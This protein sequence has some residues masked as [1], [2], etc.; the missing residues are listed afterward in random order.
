MLQPLISTSKEVKERLT[1]FVYNVC[2]KQLS[3]FEEHRFTFYTRDKHYLRES[4]AGEKRE[5]LIVPLVQPQVRAARSAINGI[6][7]SR[8]PIF[9][10]VAGKEFMEEAAVLTALMARDATFYNW[11]E[12]IALSLGDGLRYNVM[13]T[14]VDWAQTKR[15]VYQTSEGP[16]KLTEVVYAGNKLQRLNPYNVF[17]DSRVD[18]ATV[19]EY[20]DFAGFV[21]FYPRARFEKFWHEHREF[22]YTESKPELYQTPTNNPTPYYYIPEF[23]KA[24]LSNFHEV[25]FWENFLE[26][27]STN[28]VKR[29]YSLGVEIMEFFLRCVPKDF[30]ISIPDSTR[31]QVLQLIF[32][33]GKLIHLS[34]YISNHSYIP[35]IFGQPYNDGLGHNNKSFSESLEDIQTLASKLWTAELQST[36]RIVADRAIY[37]PALI[38][39]DDINTTNPAAKIPLRRHSYNANPAQAYYQIPYDDRSIGLRLNQAREIYN[40]GY[41]V[42]GQNPVTQGQ[43]IKGNKTNYQFGESMAASQGRIIDIALSL[44]SH[45]FAP[46]KYLLLENMLLNVSPQTIFDPG[47][48]EKLRVDPERL[49]N[50]GFEFTIA[51]G[52]VEAQRIANLEG[53]IQLFTMAMQDQ[54]FRLE[55]D[56][57]KAFAY[58]AEILGVK[59]F[60]DF[61]L[62]PE[63]Q[64]RKLEMM[65]AT[66]AAQ[67][68]GQQTGKAIGNAAIQ[69]IPG[70]GE[71]GIQ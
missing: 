68:T 3:N 69:S 53:F 54:E 40:F 20:G 15:F 31:P 30:G 52:L 11:R 49:K 43:F 62:T 13:A 56:I 66:N 2:I 50:V 10:A 26:E 65:F 36:R 44:E 8:E 58:I 63:E 41:A 29:R 61:K 14:K 27:N 32:A 51:D 60:R 39:P 55:Y 70:S 57:P 9:Q 35:I 71:P 6:F 25:N 47:T 28:A 22:L 33:N 7:T 5:E 46:M 12:N 45:F 38:D 42:T 34:Q 67:S 24:H 59:H 64:R 1:S 16:R 23:S 4:A 18:L 17:F 21:D 48:Q 19:H 37:N